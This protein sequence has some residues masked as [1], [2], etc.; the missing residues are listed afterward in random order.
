MDKHFLAD[1][2]QRKL[3][4]TYETARRY[5]EDARVDAKSGAPR[6]VNVAQAARTRLEQAEA[7][8]AAAADF[9]PAAMR[10]G[11]RIGLGALVEV[12]DGEAG[13]TLFVAPA[14]AGEELT[15]PDGDGFLHVV[16]PG[17]PLGKALIGKKVGDVVEVLVKGELTEW[18]ITW[19]S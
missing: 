10:K 17:S 1:Q 7:A 5:D 8:W 16:T 9:K 15:G 4:A 18:E 3:R 12:E 6:A 13:K 2:L 14:G 11:E 19:A